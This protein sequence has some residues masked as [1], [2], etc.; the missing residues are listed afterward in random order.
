MCIGDI[1]H[2]LRQCTIGTCIGA[3][4]TSLDAADP[5]VA[6]LLGSG[7]DRQPN[8]WDGM[9]PNQILVRNQERL[10]PVRS[11]IFYYFL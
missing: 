8:V 9:P 1:E 3:S 10:A 4:Q 6:Y 11:F 2:S 7:Q 5:S